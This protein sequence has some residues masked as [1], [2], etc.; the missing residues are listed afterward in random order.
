MVWGKRSRN[1]GKE[2]VGPREVS[3]R[4]QWP[5]RCAV[6]RVAGSWWITTNRLRG[7]RLPCFLMHQGRRPHA[8]IKEGPP[9][10]GKT[11]HNC[12]P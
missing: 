2:V 1:I 12:H 9:P 6:G 4:V 7:A 5:R 3:S 8:R 10:D 11:K